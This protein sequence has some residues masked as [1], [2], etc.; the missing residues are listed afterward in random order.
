MTPYC[1]TC[2]ASG[3]QADCV[4]KSK[5]PQYSGVFHPAKPSSTSPT[6]SFHRTT[7]TSSH[8]PMASGA[9]SNSSGTLGTS[10]PSIASQVTSE[11]TVVVDPLKLALSGVSR[12]D[13]NMVLYARFLF[14]YG[15]LS[16]L[17][18]FSRVLF[19][20]HRMQF[21]FHLRLSKQIAIYRGDFSDP[22]VHPFYIHFAHYMGK[23][24]EAHQ[25]T[26]LTMIYRYIY[27]SGTK[28][29]L[30]AFAHPDHTPSIRD[31]ITFEHARGSRSLFLCAGKSLHRPGL[32][33][34]SYPLFMGR[35]PEE[36]Y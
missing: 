12:Q 25:T 33:I 1:T 26:P 16:D 19:L 10:S 3:K 22:T 4:Y 14:R 28:G 27:I 15:I 18:F 9:L 24:H 35:I 23:R 32:H 2:V 29:K 6:D 8:S 21:G 13:S 20:M 17:L 5:A 31:G 11:P 30:L 7:S 36:S 34:H